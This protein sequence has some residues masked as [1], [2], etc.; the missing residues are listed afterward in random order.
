MWVEVVQGVLTHLYGLV[1]ERGLQS[2]CTLD[3]SVCYTARITVPSTAMT[4]V[5]SSL[6]QKLF[7]LQ[8]PAWSGGPVNY[9]TVCQG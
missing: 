6:L 9:Y 3:K 8:K 5:T 4:A 1:Q 2:Y 7:D